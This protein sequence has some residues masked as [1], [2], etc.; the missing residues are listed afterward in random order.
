[1]DLIKTKSSSLDSNHLTARP[2]SVQMA[3][4]NSKYTSPPSKSLSVT[5][6][7]FS[8]AAIST[9]LP[10]PFKETVSRLINS[11]AL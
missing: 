8:R 3:K 6:I 7:L 9:L 11:S 2:Q 4:V 5:Q 10:T 1:M